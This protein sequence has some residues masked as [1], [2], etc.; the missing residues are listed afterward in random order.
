VKEI[1]H[2]P[3]CNSEDLSPFLS[4]QDYFGSQESFDLLKCSKCQG[5]STSPQPNEDEILPYYKSNAYISHGDQSAGIISKVYR[6]IQ[7]RNFHY[8]RKII[9]KYVLNKNILDY[10][11]G[12]GHFLKYLSDLEWETTGIEPDPRAKQQAKDKGINITELDRLNKTYD[13]ISLF[14]VLEHVHEQHSTIQK[15]KNQLTANGVIII[16]LPNY[17]SFDAK[18]YDKYWAGYDVPRHLYHF[19]Q[20]TVHD[21]FKKFGLNIVSTHPLYYDSYYVSLLSEEYKHGKKNLLRGLYN[22]F[23]SNQRAKKT[24]E[25]SSLI[26]ILSQ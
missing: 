14:H 19:N 7:N 3:L 9:Q 24:K 18:H 1:Q 20:N 22:G 17:L 6:I 2:C 11:C 5:L 15:L 16:A 10:G 21:L 8:K 26:Y 23:T 25:Y 12:T 13:C 4:T